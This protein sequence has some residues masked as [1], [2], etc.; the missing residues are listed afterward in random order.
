MEALQRLANERH[1][2]V[3]ALIRQGVDI[4]LQHP[5]VTSRKEQRQRAMEAIGRFTSQDGNANVSHDHDQYLS[6][7]YLP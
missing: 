2:S 5:N 6:E 3:A 1:V 4:L 7:A